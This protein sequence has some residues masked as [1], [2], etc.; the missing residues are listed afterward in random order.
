MDAS[1]AGGIDPTTPSVVILDAGDLEVAVDS[2]LTVAE[3][4]A[5][6]VAAHHTLLHDVPKLGSALVHSNPSGPDGFDYH[7]ELAHH[8]APS[9]QRLSRRRR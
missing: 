2:T 4:H 5:V 8:S 3:G 7:A 6:A 1:F 9:A